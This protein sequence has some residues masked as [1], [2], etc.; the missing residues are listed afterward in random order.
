M[1]T[2][3]RAGFFFK[4][5]FSSKRQTDRQTEV[6]ITDTTEKFVWRFANKFFGRV[7]LALIIN[8]ST[9]FSHGRNGGEW[10]KAERGMARDG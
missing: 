4:V 3:A 6:F 5:F 7:G 8:S 10:G 9:L 1:F 2:S